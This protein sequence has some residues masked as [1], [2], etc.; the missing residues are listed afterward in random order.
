M[1]KAVLW[2]FGGVFTTSP[3]E[4]FARFEADKNLP[5]DFIRGVNSTNPDTN[6]WAQLEASDISVEIFDGL[7]AEE[8]RA[9]GHEVRGS[10]VLALLSG[11]LRPAMV[12]ALQRIA[13]DY[14]TACLTNNVRNTGEGPGMV[15]GEERA[16]AVQAVFATFDAVIESSVVG[17]RKPNPDFYLLACR[18]LGVEPS[19]AIF[20]D[21]LGI[22]LK[23]ARALGMTTIKVL[24]EDQALDDLGALLGM[25]LR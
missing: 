4:N 17:I 20:L 7:F 24:S 19:E 10:E 6:A 16:A 18:T 2:D 21:D 15:R 5:T 14:K 9:R 25:A 22:N 23:P 8:S 13:A 11:E 3:F 1:F 12:D